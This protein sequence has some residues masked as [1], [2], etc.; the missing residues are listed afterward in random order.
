MNKVPDWIIKNVGALVLLCGLS[1]GGIYV[2]DAAVQQAQRDEYTK[3][4]VADQEASMA[5]KVA[6]QLGRYYESGGKH[7][8][9]PYV[10]RVGKGKPLT[11]CNGITGSDVIAG[12]WYTPADCYQMEKGR[13]LKHE[14]LAKS[15]M[16]RWETYD[17]LAQSTF[18][19]FIH[20][21]GDTNFL[22]STMLIKAKRGD[23]EGAC[24][25]NP[26]WVNGTVNNVKTALPG[27]VIRGNAND[28]ICRLWRI[29]PTT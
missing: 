8:G 26:R 21:K 16:N 3:A 6:M 28:E 4:L 5:V 27:L 17:P 24:R 7:I 2:N 12:K 10:D 13:Y 14:R 20:N 22:G 23:L 15:A 9:T 19:D 11:V 29:Q 1:V 25:Q 18:L